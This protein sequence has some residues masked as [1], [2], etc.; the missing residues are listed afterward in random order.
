MYEPICCNST[1]LLCADAISLL[2]CSIAKLL[3][4]AWNKKKNN[5]VKT[6]WKKKLFSLLFLYNAQFPLFI[7]CPSH[8]ILPLKSRCPAVAS[9][10]CPWRQ[11]LCS[12]PH[13][14][15]QRQNIT[16]QP[17]LCYTWPSWRG[18]GICN[19]TRPHILS[20]W[21]WRSFLCN[22]GVWRSAWWR[23]ARCGEWWFL[24]SKGLWIMF[25]KNDQKHIAKL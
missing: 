18:E 20:T 23:G 19:R 2:R 11:R 7:L 12:S 17:M 15:T 25:K 14:L 9:L 4:L 1:C 21:T 5:D 8:L 3:C 6:R 16:K 22:K 13:V 24:R 10:S